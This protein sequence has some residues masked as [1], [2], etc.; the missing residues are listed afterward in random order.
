MLIRAS[1]C[2]LDLM[3]PARGSHFIEVACTTYKVEQAWFSAWRENTA[4]SV[5][6][7]RGVVLRIKGV[8]KFS[9][10]LEATSF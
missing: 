3:L 5:W 10:N 4:R 6:R 7:M 8:Y 2:L 1:F 9:K